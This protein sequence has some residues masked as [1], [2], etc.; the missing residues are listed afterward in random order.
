M[1]RVSAGGRLQVLS[2][3]ANRVTEGLMAVL[4]AALTLLLGAQIAGRFVFGYSL[5]WS[6]EL[7]RFLLVWISFLGVSAAARRGVHPAID[8]AVRALPPAAARLAR[9]AALALSLLFM[10]LVVLYGGELVLRTW[11]QRSPSLGLPMSWPYLAV[12]L[13]ALLVLLHW[14]ALGGTQSGESGEEERRG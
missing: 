8:G 10:A 1:G 12:P 13:S 6:D 3:G 11:R 9:G 14:A 7:A 4:L 5:P 2:R